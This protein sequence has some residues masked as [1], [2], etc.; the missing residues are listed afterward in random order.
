MTTIAYNHKSMTL[1]IDGRLTAG[2]II[3]EDDFDKHLM[4][5]GEYWF[6][7]G[8]MAD[9]S[10]LIELKHN[11]KPD[12]LPDC[13]AIMVKNG[14]ANLVCFNDSY[15]SHSSITTNYSIGSGSEFALAAMDFGKNAKQAVEYAATRDIYTGGL[16]RVFDIKKMKFIESKINR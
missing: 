7:C 3:T 14:K 9:N 15:C 8:A 10:Q 5:E 13:T 4:K 11:D 6:F 16:I 2:N 1:A 12:P